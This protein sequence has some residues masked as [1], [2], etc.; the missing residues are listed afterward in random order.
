MCGVDQSEGRGQGGG[1]GGGVEARSVKLRPMTC[2]IWNNRCYLVKIKST[3]M[4]QV[5]R[6]Y[7]IGDGSRVDH[8]HDISS[9]KGHRSTVIGNY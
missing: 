8:A 6:M 2:L 1:G 7:S 4:T 9:V 3:T 5:C